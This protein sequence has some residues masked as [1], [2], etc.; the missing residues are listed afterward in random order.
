M[1][2]KSRQVI[3]GVKIMGAEMRAQGAREAAQKAIRDADRAEAEAWP[4]RMEGY[5]GP[6]Q[7]PP[8]IGQCLNGGLGLAGGGMQSLQYAGKPT[9]RRHPPTA[10][11]AALEVGG[12]TEMPIMPEG[13][14]RAARAQ[15]D[16]D[17]GDHTLQAVEDK[18]LHLFQ[19][20]DPSS[21]VGPCLLVDFDR[22]RAPVP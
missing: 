10:R 5:G 7:P 22:W 2:T 3:W 19:S 16:G 8:T 11:H 14:S 6:A 21:R 12:F 13:S 20:S 4:L 18:L 9:S 1:S 17:A 15:A